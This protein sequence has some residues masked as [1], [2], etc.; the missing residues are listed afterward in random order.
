MK[1]SF[2]AFDQGL[3]KAVKQHGKTE[4]WLVA[5]IRKQMNLTVVKTKAEAGLVRVQQTLQL[6][7][8][9]H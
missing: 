6:F 3:C 9:E 1:S 5:G 7:T 8:A 2:C 4:H